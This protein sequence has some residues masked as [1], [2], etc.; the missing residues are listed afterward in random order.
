MQKQ[1]E[2]QVEAAILE[3]G[4]IEEEGGYGI[5]VDAVTR[6]S[7]ASKT[8]HQVT[9]DLFEAIRLMRLLWKRGVSPVNLEDVLESLELP[10]TS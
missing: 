6:S 7:T 8:V 9:G 10:F 2:P 1:L 5:R 3:Y 4:V